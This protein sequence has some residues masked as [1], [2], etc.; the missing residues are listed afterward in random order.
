MTESSGNSILDELA[1][2]GTDPVLL[3]K[4]RT[5]RIT[6]DKQLPPMEFLLSL[7]DVPCCPRGELVAFTGK[8]KS[9]KTFVM[10]MLMA[11]AAAPRG[12][13]FVRPSR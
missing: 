1:K 4:L 5:D 7:F 2:A 11:V 10:S 12:L 8:A 9:G 13:A 6:A 3:D